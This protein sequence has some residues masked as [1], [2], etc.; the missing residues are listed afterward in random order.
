MTGD[1]VTAGNEGTG[2]MDSDAVFELVGHLLEENSIYS[3]AKDAW[4]MSV[5]LLRIVYEQ[6][7]QDQTVPSLHRAL[8]E[9]VRKGLWEMDYDDEFE[10]DIVVLL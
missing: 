5:P 10:A 1:A 3:Q 7:T 6:S 2:D 4:T 8:E 9:G